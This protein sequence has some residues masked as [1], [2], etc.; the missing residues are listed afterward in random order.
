MSPGPDLKP[1]ARPREHLHESHEPQAPSADLA[2]CRLCQF[3]SCVV[4]GGPSRIE[5]GKVSSADHFESTELPGKRS[6]LDLT[7]KVTM[8]GE[9]PERLPCSR[10]CS[11]R[12][13]SAAQGNSFL[14]A[15]HVKG[16]VE[17]RQAPVPTVTTKGC[18]EAG[19]SKW[20]FKSRGNLPNNLQI[21]NLFF[22]LRTKLKVATEW[23][24]KRLD[25]AGI[26][27]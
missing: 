15:G 8:P 22:F 21:L 16:V 24:R 10:F 9:R 6:A 12:I 11:G 7:D 2:S 27:S 19:A 14:T 4:V 3:F 20:R 17:L 18:V 5:S 25:V 1:Q 13:T 23:E 26:S